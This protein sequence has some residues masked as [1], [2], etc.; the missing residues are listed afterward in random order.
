MSSLNKKRVVLL[1]PTDLG[2]VIVE[3]LVFLLD[4]YQVLLVSMSNFV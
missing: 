4:F 2:R 3:F 1:V